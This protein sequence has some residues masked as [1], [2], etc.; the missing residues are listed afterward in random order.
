MPTTFHAIVWMDQQAAQVVMFDKEHSESIK[1][2]SHSHAAHQGKSRDERGFYADIAGRLA[3]T[4]EVLLTGPGDAHDKFRAWCAAHQPAV[5]K[6]IVGS[7]PSDHPSEGQL[8]VLARKYFSGFD[9]MALD[10]ALL[11]RDLA[12]GQLLPTSP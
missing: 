8:V 11:R 7:M 2:R 4:H 3:G 6:V 12:D 9:R 1:V 5:A 10:P